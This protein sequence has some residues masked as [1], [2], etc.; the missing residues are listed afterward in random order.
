[1]L[2]A[3]NE[4]K[5]IFIT[6]LYFTI[7]PAV[8]FVVSAICFLGQGG[9]GGGHA[10]YDFIIGCC[11]IPFILFL[12]DIPLNTF[13]ETHDFALIVIVPSIANTILWFILGVILGHIRQRIKK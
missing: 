8:L 4:M 6:G 3:R 2:G 1:M 12:E 5:K 10:P 13:L 7:I 11:G 9:F